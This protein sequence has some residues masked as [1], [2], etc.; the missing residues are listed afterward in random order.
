[1]TLSEAEEI[2]YKYEYWTDISCTCFMG[3]PPCGKCVECPSE[4]QYDEAYKILEGKSE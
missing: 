4:E 2:V 1:M 3:N